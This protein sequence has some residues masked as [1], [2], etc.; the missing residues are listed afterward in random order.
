MQPISSPLDQRCS[1]QLFRLMP[2][3]AEATHTFCTILIHK[4]ETALCARDIHKTFQ[5]CIKPSAQY[6]WQTMHIQSSRRFDFFLLD[7]EN[8]QTFRSS[9]WLITHV[10]GFFFVFLQLGCTASSFWDAVVLHSVEAAKS[11]VGT[12]NTQSLETRVGC[13]YFTQ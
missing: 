7:C 3:D 8:I 5:L 2:P 12:P 4:P 11:E 6:I 1:L 10:W 9:L 13:V